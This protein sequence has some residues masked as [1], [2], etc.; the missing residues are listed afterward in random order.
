MSCVKLVASD[1]GTIILVH[2]VCRW[3]LSGARVHPLS[4]CSCISKLQL[5][6]LIVATLI[7]GTNLGVR[8]LNE[9][10]DDV[11]HV[12]NLLIRRD[13]FCASSLLP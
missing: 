10:I 2:I 5:F 6:N 11:S 12:I 3:P 8:A 4:E 7:P 9:K 1:E 13:R